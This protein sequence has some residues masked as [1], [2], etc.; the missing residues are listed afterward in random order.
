MSWNMCEEHWVLL[1][2][3]VLSWPLP[4]VKVFFCDLAQ[5][6]WF[7]ATFRIGLLIKMQK[8]AFYPPKL[9]IP[10]NSRKSANL[11]LIGRKW[12]IFELFLVENP[13]QDLATL[14]PAW[15]FQYQNKSWRGHFCSTF[16]CQKVPKIKM[17]KWVVLLFKEDQTYSIINTRQQGTLKIVNEKVVNVKHKDSWY[18]GT[19]IGEEGRTQSSILCPDPDERSKPWGGIGE[20]WETVWVIWNVLL[21]S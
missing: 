20:S 16:Q 9:E 11:K 7:D 10:R 21:E 3:Y 6:L 18:T 17:K 8:H 19:V 12:P 1:V 5:F 15:S 4:F 14:P 2:C 13:V